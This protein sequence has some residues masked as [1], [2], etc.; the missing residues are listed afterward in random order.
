MVEEMI[1]MTKRSVRISYSLLIAA[2]IVG[3]IVVAV[4]QQLFANAD[5][6]LSAR[7]SLHQAWQSAGNSGR[8][9]YRTEI[10]Q[11]THPTM[12]LENAGRSA[13]TARVMIDG[14][15]DVQAERMGFHLTATNQ[16]PLE[17]EIVKG[18]AK[19]RLGPDQP[20]SEIEIGADLFAPGGDPMGFLNA[21]ENVRVVTPPQPSPGRGGS[22]D[23]V[24]D[25][26]VPPPGSPLGA[27]R[28]GGGEG[29]FPY[30]LL[31][32]AYSAAITRYQFDMNGLKYAQFMR[33][34]METYLRERGELPAGITLGLVDK[35]VEMSGHGEI[36]VHQR[37]DGAAYPVRQILHLEFPPAAGATN[38]I[39]ADIT[40]SFSNW[41]RVAPAYTALDWRSPGTALASALGLARMT[42]KEMRQMSFAF[43][44]ML[45]MIGGMA[46]LLLYRRTYL[47]RLTV[48]STMT[49]SMVITPLLQ[50][51]QVS[52]FYDAQETRQQQF[53]DQQTATQEEATGFN[54]HEN[55]LASTDESTQRVAM[56]PAS[57]ANAMNNSASAD[58]RA[59]TRAAV[60]QQATNCVITADSDCDGDGLTDNVEIY[61]LGTRIDLVDT[62]SDGISDGREVTPYYWFGAWV[63]DPLNAD[64]NGDGIRDGDECIMLNDVI[65]DTVATEIDVDAACIDTDIDGIPDAHDFDNDGDGVP[66]TADL[67]ANSFISVENNST[68]NLAI[69][70]AEADTNVIVDLQVR[71]IDERHL[72][73]TNS[74]LDWPDQD[75][76]GQ[77][78][79]MTANTLG[80]N[81]GDIQLIPMLE[82]T[83]PYSSSNPAGGLP[84][85]TTLTT[86][87]TE[88]TPIATWLDTTTTNE[89]AMSVRLGPNNERIVNVPLVQVTDPNGGSPVAWNA[90]FPYRM[91]AGVTEWGASHQVKVVW[92]VNGQS[93]ECRISAGQS[94]SYCN[95]TANWISTTTLL[96]I[97]PE[98]FMVTGINIQEHHGADALMVTQASGVGGSYEEDLWH[99]AATL[100]DTWLQAQAVSN[101]R[102]TIGDIPATYT[103]WGIPGGN[104][105]HNAI[106]D[107]ADDTALFKATDK[108]AVQ[109]FLESVYTAPASGTT[110]TV[111]L[112]AEEANTVVQL[113]Q[114]HLVGSGENAVIVSSATYTNSLLTVDFSNL[115]VN[116][117][118]MMRWQSYGFNGTSWEPVALSSYL[119]DLA[120]RLDSV[121]TTDL[122][123]SANIGQYTSVEEA[124]QGSIFLAQNFYFSLF[125]SVVAPL[126]NS[127]NT[128]F[129]AAVALDNAL[130]QK[131]GVPVWAIVSAMADKVLNFYAAIN[132]GGLDIPTVDPTVDV[133]AN[134]A[135]VRLATSKAAVLEAYG[136]SI[137]GNSA[138]AIG[139]ALNELQDY[140]RVNVDAGQF[141][142]AY[143]NALI[144]ANVGSRAIATGNTATSSWSNFMTG[145][146][147]ATAKDAT[148]VYNHYWYTRQGSKIAQAKA[149]EDVAHEHSQLLKAAKSQLETARTK[150]N[151]LQQKVS[152]LTR[153]RDNITIYFADANLKSTRIRL[154]D[155]SK[156]AAKAK[157]AIIEAEQKVA[158]LTAK[159]IPTG[160]NPA[161]LSRVAKGW[162]AAGVVIAIGSAGLQIGLALANGQVEAGTPAFDQLLAEQIASVVV[163]VISVVL[164]LVALT[165]AVLGVALILVAIFDLV[166]GVICA[167][168][169][170]DEKKPK[171]AAWVCGG[172]TGALTKALAH[173]INDTTPMVDVVRDDRLQIA[174]A[175]PTVGSESGVD[176]LVVGNA[177]TLSGSVTTTLYMD[178]ASALGNG[179]PYQWTDEN[180]ARSTFKYRI[181]G[182]E[183]DIPLALDGID[184]LPVPG[185]PE[186]KVGKR[187]N[188]A[189]YYQGLTIEPFSYAFTQPGINQGLPAYLS[190]GYVVREQ[191]CWVGVC[192]V[193]KFAD[194]AHQ[195]LAESFLFDVFPAT[196]EEFRA[197]AIFPDEAGKDGYRLAWDTQFPRLFDADGDG[198]AGQ[199]AG[200]ADPNDSTPDSDADGLPDKFEVDKAG[201]DPGKSDSD[202]DGLTDYWEYFYGTNPALADTD[203]DGLTDSQEFQHVNVL[204]PYDNSR[205]TNDTP[206]A[207]EPTGEF[208]VGGW[209]IVYDFDNEN[210]ALVTRVN[211]DPLDPDS[212]DDGLSDKQERTYAY[213][214]NVASTLN[215]LSLDTQI[216]SDS[217]TLPYVGPNG[218]IN[219]SAVI[220]NELTFPYAQGLLEAEL[221]LDQVRRRQ[222]TGVIA[223]QSY[224]TINGAVGMA[225]TGL[226]TSQPVDMGIRA[227]AIIADPTGRNLW[228]RMNEPAGSTTFA[229][230]SYLKHDASC[231]TCPTANARTLT[232]ANST[233]TVP[234]NADFNLAN[235]SVGFDMQRT[236]DATD[237]TLFA[238]NDFSIAL[239]SGSVALRTQ[240][241]GNALVS[242]AIATNQWVHVMATVDSG[243][244]I[245]LYVDGVKRGTATG[246]AGTT[247]NANLAIGWPSGAGSVIIDEVELY[248]TVLTD[249]TIARRYGKPIL[250]I[251]L[252]NNSAWADDGVSCAGTGCPTLTGSGATFTQKQHLT[253]AAPDLSGDQF[254]FIT[255]IKP[256]ARTAPMDSAVAAHYGRD[257][258]KDWQAVFGDM[259]Y[260]SA[261]SATWPFTQQVYPS[262]FVSDDGQLRMLMANSGV[263]CDVRTDAT[264]VLTYGEWQQL[265]I[266][267]DGSNFTFYVNGEI[268]PGVTTG[269]SCAGIA[270]PAASTFYLGSANEYG[271]AWVDRVFMENTDGG[272]ESVE[273]RLNRNDDGISGNIWNPGRLVVGWDGSEVLTL[274]RD[275][276]H[277]FLLPNDAASSW[278]RLYR[279]IVKPERSFN[280]KWPNQDRN[281]KQ[282]TGIRNTSHLGLQRFDFQGKDQLSWK[283]RGQLYF[284]V[285]NDFFHGELDDFQVYNYALTD[286]TIADIFKSTATALEMR[287]DEAPGS[288]TFT[289]ISGNN[290]VASCSGTTCP[291][292]GVP[293]RNNQALDFDGV[294]DFLTLSS[295]GAETGLGGRDNWAVAMWVK[296]RNFR[297]TNDSGYQMLLGTAEN[298]GIGLY[299]GRPIVFPNGNAVGAEPYT[300]RNSGAN[301]WVHL[302]VTFR[303]IVGVGTYSF[304][305]NGKLISSKIGTGFG[306]GDTLYIGKT[307]T[308]GNSY[309]FYD[310]LIDDLRIYKQPLSAAEIQAIVRQAPRLNLHMDED[311]ADGT[312]KDDSENRY[313]A[314]CTGN[315]CP[316]AGDKGQMREAA[317]FDGNDAL[318]LSTMTTMTRTNFSVGLWVKPTKQSETRQRLLTKADANL[319]NATFRLWLSATPT[320]TVTFDRQHTCLGSEG[321]WHTVKAATPLLEDQWNH[322]VGVHNGATGTMQIYI[323]GALAGTETGTGSTVCTTD[324][325]VRIGQAFYGGIDEVSITDAALSG[326]QV[327]EQYAYQSAWFDT[328]NQH[329]VE[330]DADIPTVDLSMVPST[331]SLI[332]QMIAIQASDGPHIL[333]PDAV[334]Y[335]ING[336]GWQKATANGSA[337]NAWLL[338]FQEGAGTHTLE[339]RATDIVGNLSPV[340]STTIQVDA[341]A[342]NVTITTPS[343]PMQAV[344][345]LTI[346]GTAS[347][348]GSGV[349]VNKLTISTTDHTGAPVNGN[350][351]GTVAPD[352]AWAAIQPFASPPYGLYDITATAVDEEGNSGSASS[353]LRLDGL[354]PYADV[355]ED[356]TYLNPSISNTFRGIASDVP[357]PAGSRSLH[358][359][360]EAGDGVFVDGTASRFTMSCTTC[361]ATGS[362]GRHGNAI[363]FD[364]VDDVLDFNVRAEITATTPTEMLGLTNGSFTIMAWVNGSDWSGDHAILGSSPTTAGDGFYLGIQNSRPILGYGGDDSVLDQTIPAGQWVHLT[365][366]YDAGSGERA[367]FIN[368]TQ[369]VT[370]TLGHAPFTGEGP[371]QVGRARG[372]NGYNGLLDELVI[373]AQPL[374]DETIYDIANPL[375]VGISDI[376][377]RFR[378]FAEGNLAQDAGTWI[379]ATLGST[380]S[381]F[382][383]W[384]V[385]MPTLA[386]GT[387]KI[388]LLVTDGVGNQNF[389]NGVWDGM[390]LQPDLTLTKQSATGLVNPGEAISYT[391]TY[392]N[393]GLAPAQN[394]ILS[395][396]V[397]AETSFNV[398]ASHPGW[399]CQPDGSA[400][401]NCSLALGSVAAAGSGSVTFTVN[402]NDPL[403][404]GIGRFDNAASISSDGG[405]AMPD[406][407]SSTVTVYTGVAPDLAVTIQDNRGGTVGAAQ[408][409]SYTV[410]YTNTGSQAANGTLSLVVPQQTRFFGRNLSFD[411]DAPKWKCAGTQT[412]GDI[413]TFDLGVVPI[414]GSGTETFYIEISSSAQNGDQVTTTIEITDLTLNGA[415]LN[416]ADNTDSA[417]VSVIRIFITGSDNDLVT[418]QEGE[419]ITNTGF[420]NVPSDGYE[421]ATF[422][423]PTLGAAQVNPITGI[424]SWS[425]DSSDGPDDS[426]DVTI[427]FS[428][429]EGSQI[430]TTFAISI[431]DVAPAL[432]L[433]G[434]NTAAVGT[435]YDLT[436]GNVVDPGND[437]VTACTID[438]GD[439]NS[440]SC[441]GALGGA[442]NH[443]YATPATAA[444]VAPQIRVEL[445]DEDG[446]HTAAAKQI[447]LTN[448]PTFAF[449]V[450]VV[451]QGSVTDGGG[452]AHAAGYALGKV[453]SLVTN[454]AQ[455]WALES[456][457]GA[458]AGSTNPVTVTI[459]GDTAV[460]ATF[461][462]LPPTLYTLT[463]GVQGNGSVTPASGGSYEAGTVVPLTA[464]AASGWQFVNWSGNAGGATPSTTVTMNGDKNVTAIFKELPPETHVLSLV[465]VGRGQVT[466][467]SVTGDI[468]SSVS[469]AYLSGTDVSINATAA[470]GWR[471]VGWSGAASGS[472]STSILVDADKAATAT[473]TET[474]YTVGTSVNGSGSVELNPAQAS[475]LY[476][477]VVNVTAV[478]AAGWGFDGWQGDLSGDAGGE[479]LM[480]DGN[481][482]VTALFSQRTYTLTAET[483]G[484]GSITIEPFKEQY[485]YGETVLVTAVPATD[486]IFDQWG[487][488]AGGSAISTTLTMDGNKSVLAIFAEA[489]YVLNAAWIGDGGVSVTP[490]QS[491]FVAGEA[492]TVTAEAATGSHFIGWSGDITDT[493]PTLSLVMTDDLDVVANFDVDGY[494]LT[495]NVVGN[496]VVTPT[497]GVYNVPI[498]D[499]V[500]FTATPNSGESFIGWSGDLS[501]TEL[502]ASLF[503]DSSKVVTATFSTNNPGIAEGDIDGDGAVNVLDLQRLINMIQSGVQPDPALFD[504]TWWTRAD[505]DNN[506]QWNVLDLQRIINIIQS[507]P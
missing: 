229:D 424:W 228:L 431:T 125:A 157:L 13:H 321:N 278:L 406:D 495:V 40:T 37:A 220:T 244:G 475:Y 126:E 374:D 127:S 493:A 192:A 214:P 487:L 16:P 95:D 313:D 445:T 379:P 202:C 437:T 328:I 450:N 191:T 366:R 469:Q 478:P 361:P 102:F 363:A 47:V 180:V 50:T 449:S 423:P 375:D 432:A 225:E 207:C 188:T 292:S 187:Y 257:T 23:L 200:G 216:T 337:T 248:P 113:D 88:T 316:K 456:W 455:G 164:D 378:S 416:L 472:G 277:P 279:N 230:A 84:V 62:D 178:R 324:N 118:G 273:P 89:Y 3:L 341:Q 251:D 243:T 27:G 342:P 481:K 204:Y 353:V 136:Q 334:A 72:W 249:A 135:Y 59:S 350:Q 261:H 280:K 281:Y 186:G 467:G 264:N 18:L 7:E 447:Q 473:F 86:A 389:M 460:T 199:A 8:Y 5:I 507:A 439:G 131:A 312:F 262:L 142:A 35:Y 471:F 299:Y 83:I 276:H 75:N 222:Q 155:F 46:L 156:D 233:I 170:F 385:A 294:D 48:A 272:G 133:E 39:E 240:S 24:D 219:Y 56:A 453:V 144:Y 369:P 335:R 15:M 226:T 76:S 288:T 241:G 149:I 387:Y 285:F 306:A 357:H 293:G 232:F 197:L 250:R 365:W 19:G 457:S 25:Q 462:K 254:T 435:P 391:L 308:S 1:I 359:H 380:S 259:T 36:W 344:N 488:D 403:A 67:D 122:L 314:T 28:L 49:A 370:G 297:G 348:S 189:R 452:S 491:T 198:L 499:T 139:Q 408:L 340:A 256:L 479:S 427:Y 405:D 384:E 394:V 43:G 64:S 376:Q 307:E 152:Y 283:L 400:G 386:A 9:E 255:W 346:N 269:P 213:N 245:S 468:G 351:S 404:P 159:P 298:R 147:L 193:G 474:L 451:G 128:D 105:R 383:T 466:N 442:L 397:P 117:V 422:P 124:R 330:L 338:Y 234:G 270:P 141:N 68:L 360:F 174:L 176:G 319:F 331:V 482:S 237:G 130:H 154:L 444:G 506:G 33:K 61:E 289:D 502:T 332:G 433:T 393:I 167:A 93:D 150:L 217:G 501:G 175:A 79:R 318:T 322:V 477:D 57:N 31:P 82:I 77:L 98:E 310:G 239:E 409:I 323:N 26:S 311:V 465:A 434:A 78:Q 194:T 120:S 436:L 103:S 301:R 215:V 223:P 305:V 326:A 429:P 476:G 112:A 165:S 296:P 205:L 87:I 145:D 428:S 402:V 92:F 134:S 392:N 208:L 343:T 108:P 100:Q 42:A 295:T 138:S 399:S 358:L 271:Y 349:A 395:E 132:L 463:T 317:T 275:I 66:D 470:P 418:A 410:S 407:N 70:A 12:R 227:G 106:A 315:A 177:I 146:G 327:A 163:A 364:G 45:L 367:F 333:P 235:F 252:R 490:D 60:Q 6:P 260:D 153:A 373:Y 51:E 231:V 73:W 454:P 347:D 81:T 65:T 329:Q 11:T 286:D 34:E 185:R 303:R 115:E 486:W 52:A 168:T 10:L 21:A 22:R 206:P 203:G 184:W 459:T 489:T 396:V 238:M 420:I 119:D 171:V 267:Y 382:T 496:G 484:S 413:C 480:I 500:P 253:A 339:A 425:W 195:S 17:I 284:G 85:T 162:A 55:P 304:Y 196:I 54:P 121:L 497:A 209:T 140:P 401:S 504:S 29:S 441:F 458:V 412:A 201:F 210:N 483:V 182:S 179:Y 53:A 97:Y 90:R 415:D 291:L 274:A 494:P 190:E 356:A 116:T 461:V 372:G 265:A 505:L 302:A 492:V 91:Q 172:I 212:D 448:L 381:N 263:S 181:Q 266:R 109:A 111:L 414:G 160:P 498:S 411:P 362:A 148:M 438:W 290:L 143:D 71:P 129:S 151:P 247:V 32:E 4:T 221:P 41:Q 123:N 211:A 421:F 446:T 246:V 94:S 464:T 218:N 114:A 101:A 44:L 300:L 320:M 371:V 161:K 99:L 287:F 74:I 282:I 14:E 30:D 173:F 430:S 345:S 224:A 443:T 58:L 503:M 309:G 2:G 80:N 96:Q 242:H 258:A 20:W 236:A 110:A 158:Q 183:Q 104:L 137:S 63:L 398:A 419:T 325:P 388:D 166:I 107:L 426:Q 377:V 355:V 440:E 336:G 485:A 368:G 352:G 69:N 169:R 38:W 417:M 268:V 354:P 390:L